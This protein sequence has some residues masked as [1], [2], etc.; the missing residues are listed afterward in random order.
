MPARVFP[1]STASARSSRATAWPRR[2]P[3]AW[4]ARRRAMRRCSKTPSLALEMAL[5]RGGDQAVV[6]DKVNFEFYG[7]RSK[8]TEKRTKV[9]SRVMASALGELIEDA[10]A[11]LRHG[12]QPTPTWTRS[13]RRRASAASPAR[14]ARSAQIVIDLENNAVHPMIA[15]APGS[16]RSTPAPS[17]PR[18]TPFCGCSRGTLLVVVDTN[19][20]GQRRVRAAAARRCNRVAVIDHHRRGSK[21]Y[22]ED[23]A[24]TTTSPTPPPPASW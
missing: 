9:K 15:Q 8:I 21:L 1:S 13:A 19:R 18:A 24:R 6:K 17:S 14:R 23:G 20:P 7:G 11:G 3:S 4:G 12:P 10:R 16:S 2:S 5:S 22:R